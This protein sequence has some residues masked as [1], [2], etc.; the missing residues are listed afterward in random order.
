MDIISIKNSYYDKYIYFLK[1]ICISSRTDNQ[2]INMNNYLFMNFTS[3]DDVVVIY[4]YIY[5]Y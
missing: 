4:I 1:T 2:N 5:I 3:N